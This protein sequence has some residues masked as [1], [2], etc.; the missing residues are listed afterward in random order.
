MMSDLPANVRPVADRHGKIRY[1]FRRKGWPSA[2]LP[3]VPG[4]AAFHRAY[5]EIIE[6]GADG[7][8]PAKAIHKVAA[9]SLDDLAIQMK[10]GIKWQKK[11]A[12]TRHVQ[13]QIIDR[14]MDTVSKA[15]TR[16]GDRPVSEVTVGWLDRILAGMHETPAAANVLRGVLS[17]LMRHAIKLGW[18]KDNPVAE[19][20]AYPEGAGHPDWSEDDI[21][22]FRA[23]HA[24]GTM[25]RLTMELA[26]NTAARRCN[27][28]TL[29]RDDIKDG[30]I[31]VAHAKDNNEASVMMLRSTREALDALPAAP[32]KHLV[33]NAYG[34]PF[35]VGGLGNRMRKWC[36]E[37]GMKDRSLHGLRK[38]MSRRIA[39]SNGT[40]A[41]GQ[42]VT[43]HKKAETFT[44][45]RAAAN[46][47]RLADAAV[48]NVASTF[49]EVGQIAQN[50]LGVS[51]A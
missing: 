28:A 17:S 2:Y 33:T 12:Q 43:G 24:L 6:R 42:A 29:T 31:V 11:A 1:R 40:D 49:D 34:K 13:S 26:L 45:Y 37:A 8:K 44:H 30:R 7:T 27:V 18:R 9:K 20:D 51:D 23:H 39:E 46:R 16:Y 47:V 32:I 25:A 4:S 38:A 14:F 41:M 10:A 19:T 22:Q 50:N 36:N 35:S 48:S 5:A 3:G 15:G 21:A